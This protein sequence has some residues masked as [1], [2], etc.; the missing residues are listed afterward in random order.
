MNIHFIASMI[1]KTVFACCFIF[2]S[3][4]TLSAQ[5]PHN[6]KRF[7][8]S[9]YYYPNKNGDYE[10]YKAHGFVQQHTRSNKGRIFLLPNITREDS[11]IE[12]IAE[13]GVDFNPL[14]Q[15]SKVAKSIII[16]VK[17]DHS[18][19]TQTQLPAF[20][21]ALDKGISLPAYLFPMEQNQTGEPVVYPPA[22]FMTPNFQEAN[23][24]YL[25]EF[26]KQ[27]E[28][29]K[30][31]EDYQKELIAMSELEVYVVVDNEIIASRVFGQSSILTGSDTLTNISVV[32]PTI[33]VQN[34]IARGRYGMIV[35]YKFRDAF[36][37]TIDAR[38]NAK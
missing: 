9:S 36:T 22:M 11:E 2:V 30:I 7:N 3:I 34:R 18:L 23:Q 5:V 13:N 10:L 4:Q 32:D 38:F 35:S 24:A 26:K 12:F 33:Y 6:S 21:S 27:E 28:L 17:I 20:S 25:D 15:P 37:R 19:P 14:K 1:K 8:I 29:V 31:F 16:P